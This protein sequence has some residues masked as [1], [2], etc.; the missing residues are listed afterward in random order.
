LFLKGGVHW[1]NDGTLSGAIGVGSVAQDPLFLEAEK[2]GI[3]IR[4]KQPSS[5]VAKTAD[6]ALFNF[7]P[8]EDAS[9][10]APQDGTATEEK[11]MLF[12]FFSEST[13]ENEVTPTN[14]FLASAATTAMDVS[15]PP[16]VVPVSKAVA[17]AP[18]PKKS[19]LDAAAGAGDKAGLTPRAV[20]VS[21]TAA[22]MVSI[23]RKFGREK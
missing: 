8:A 7:L 2:R 10:G 13:Q 1:G 5:A 4:M 9:A 3:D 14:P 22:E 23:A 20:S 6:S 16:A 17:S 19:A 11:G 18:V 15:A 12:G 21:I